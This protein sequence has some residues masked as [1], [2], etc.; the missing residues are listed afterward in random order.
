VTSR[1]EA[2]ELPAN[3]I[4]ACINR[5][6]TLGGQLPQ[7]RTLRGKLAGQ[8]AMAAVV[9]DQSHSGPQGRMARMFGASPLTAQGAAHHRGAVGELIVGSI[10]DGLGQSWDVL[11]GVP[12]GALSL[13]HFAVGR[14]G[15]F[16]FVVVNCHGSE[17]TV[18]SDQLIVA[19]E[20][21]CFVVTARQAAVI[22]SDALNAALNAPVSVTA[23]VV[24]VNPTKV[25]ILQQPDDV[26]VITSMQLRQ[27]LISAP[28]VLCGDQV[29]EISCAAEEDSTWPQPHQ[30]AQIALNLARLYASVDDAVS[31]ASLRKVLWIVTVSVATLLALSALI[32]ILIPI[33]SSQVMHSA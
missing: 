16:A 17:V 24:L 8:S 14:A 5:H 20:S 32:S 19:K 1:P 30:V 7:N 4:F 12:L 31:A 23:V 28:H 27:W 18:D 3:R 9:D 15:V 10:L 26:Q 6:V 22:A 13:D 33:I 21:T 11:H 29:S 2:G 25:A